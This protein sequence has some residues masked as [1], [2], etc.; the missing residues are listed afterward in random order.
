MNIERT[1]RIT[2]TH[3][4]VRAALTAYV[5]DKHRYAYATD[6][7]KSYEE[8]LKWSLTNCEDVVLVWGEAPAME[9]PASTAAKPLTDEAAT[10][11][12]VEPAT[13]ATA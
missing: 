5:H 10:E 13:S 1:C 12:S 4:E 6:A 11:P 8:C 2:L 9:A 3:E 7:P